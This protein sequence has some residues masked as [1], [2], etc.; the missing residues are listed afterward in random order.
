MK[1]LWD[2]LDKK[3]TAWYYDDIYWFNL[4]ISHITEDK[5]QEALYKKINKEF[6]W[7][8][9]EKASNWKMICVKW[10]YLIIL[11]DLDNLR[12]LTHE[13]I[14]IVFD[15]YTSRWIAI[16]LENDEVF[17]YYYSYLLSITREA[18]IKTFYK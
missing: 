10:D 3:I 4:Y 14:H 11:K 18:I 6:W 5:K 16:R 1:I 8:M 2:V 9:I 13:L 17:A 15:L 7:E 12:T